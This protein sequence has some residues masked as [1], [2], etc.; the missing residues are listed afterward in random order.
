MKVLCIYSGPWVDP[1]TKAPF[2]GPVYGET[3]SVIETKV[4]NGKIGYRLEEYSLKVSNNMPAYYRST[5]FIPLS[6]IDETELVKERED[7]FQ[8][9]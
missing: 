3:C 6:D 1:F 8:P 5:K 2:K 7:Y 4:L 9:A